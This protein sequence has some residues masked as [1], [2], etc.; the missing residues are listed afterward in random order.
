MITIYCDKCG[1]VI[2]GQTHYYKLICNISK[3]TKDA[4]GAFLRMTRIRHL[5]DTCY[6]D[7]EEWLERNAEP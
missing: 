7:F 1:N 6:A 3:P 4:Q 2:T 5:H